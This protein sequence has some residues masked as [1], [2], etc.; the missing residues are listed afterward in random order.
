MALRC[1][2]SPE[3]KGIK[4]GGSHYEKEARAWTPRTGDDSEAE[5]GA[6]SAVVVPASRP[7]ST[8]CL[9][10]P[11]A[12]LHLHSRAAA[13]R[14]ALSSRYPAA[15]H[16]GLSTSSNHRTASHRFHREPAGVPPWTGPELPA[17]ST[18]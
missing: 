15:G 1:V 16:A 4:K 8:G 17:A 7:P 2:K 3:E 14:A 5:M 11:A 10:G 13:H 18:A 9:H 6:G 12:S